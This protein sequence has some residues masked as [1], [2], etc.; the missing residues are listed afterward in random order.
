MSRFSMTV[1]IITLALSD[2]FN[3]IYSPRRDE[4]HEE[5]KDIRIIFLRVLGALRGSNVV[6]E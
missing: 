1:F 2:I 3:R 5:K 6:T 4:A